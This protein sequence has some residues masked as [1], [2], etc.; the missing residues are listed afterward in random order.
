MRSR[1]RTSSKGAILALALFLLP[2][3][4]CAQ[5]P[6]A[7]PPPAAS[8]PVIPDYGGRDSAPANAVPAAAPGDNG[9]A[10]PIAQAWRA[11]ES[12]AIVLALVVGVVFLLKRYNLVNSEGT[13]KARLRLPPN[14]NK[15]WTPAASSVVDGQ[16][17]LMVLSSQPLPGG[18][19]L[20][21]IS[22]AD[23][24]LLLGATAQN[25]SLI[26]EWETK[27]AREGAET[28]SEAAFAEYLSRAG[29]ADPTPPSG[30]AARTRMGAAGERLQSVLARSRAAASEEAEP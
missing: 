14:L 22:V 29:V 24:T 16:T 3:G 26:A 4:V 9:P 11:F 7:A 21:M 8:V 20:H 28:P 30:R 1:P 27:A 5:A 23:R 17:E 19:M 12:L 2:L 10:S 18:G 25:V 15:L 6:K 13:G